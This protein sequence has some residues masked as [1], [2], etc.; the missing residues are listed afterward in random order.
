MQTHDIE[1]TRSSPRAIAW[2]CLGIGV[3]ASV[4][5]VGWIMHLCGSGI[6]FTDEG[7][8]LNSIARPELNPTSIMQFGF[9]Y[10][11]LYQLVDQDL[12]LLRQANVLLNLGLTWA[13]F[14][15]LFLTIVRPPRAIEALPWAGLALI[16][17]TT[18]LTVFYYWLPTPNYNTLALQGLLLGGIAITLAQAGSNRANLWG[19]LLLG[20][21]A[22]LVFMAKPSTALIAGSI[23]FLGLAAS[24]RLAWRFL[25]MAI[26]TAIV[27]L[28]LSAWL[29][30]SSASRFFERLTTAVANLEKL[31]GKYS[32]IEIFRLDTFT[33]TKKETGALCLGSIFIFLSAYLAQSDRRTVQS[34]SAALA[35]G[36]LI[37]F[38]VLFGIYYFCMPSPLNFFGYQLTPLFSYSS[39]TEWMNLFPFLGLQLLA[40]PIGAALAYVA[41]LRY[42]ASPPNVALAMC[43]LVLPYAYVFGTNGNYWSATCGAAIFWSASGVALLCSRSSYPVRWP[44]LLPYTVTAF[45]GTVIIL[46]LSTE[47][48]YRQSQPL[49]RNTSIVRVGEH[50]SLR[51]SANVASYIDQLQH[52]MK[53]QGFK[54]GTP[55]IDLTGHYPAILHLIEAKPIGLA[56]L[57]GGYRGSEEF[58][59]TGLDRVS[60][61]ELR[62]SWILTEPN[63]PRCISQNILRHYGLDLTRDYQEVGSLDSP[64]AD[65]S[66]SYRQHLFKPAK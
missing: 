12:V 7:Y 28:A 37:T 9:L 31:Q 25:S 33:L 18:G 34:I 58:I 16:L 8:Y 44:Q 56:W 55:M 27:L 17:S 20:V 63:G 22:W 4:L 3:A 62:Q 39:A 57:I 47:V 32:I 59:K 29:I 49:R 35:L 51:V 41:R 66:K 50:T 60:A 65:Y 23:F 43:F 10:K 45:I 36:T 13:L 53:N 61:S 30:D 54:P 21:A 14:V 15:V 38:L 24:R 40:W 64:I 26:I 52:I 6:D 1:V 11:P 42:Q 48:P 5:F 46:T 19:Y 2:I